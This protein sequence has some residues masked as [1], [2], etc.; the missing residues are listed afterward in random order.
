[1]TN[2]RIY[3]FFALPA[4]EETKTIQSF[5]VYHLIILFS[6]LSDILISTFTQSTLHLRQKHALELSVFI[7]CL[8]TFLLSFTIY[9]KLKKNESIHA[10][11]SNASFRIRSIV[12]IQQIFPYKASFYLFTNYLPFT[13]P[14][15]KLQVT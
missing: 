5:V 4:F 8:H 15:N 6:L 2:L 12:I 10:W 11:T 3:I 7:S 9:A 13:Y 1:M 14:G